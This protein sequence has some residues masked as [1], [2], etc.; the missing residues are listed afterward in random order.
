MQ[1]IQQQERQHVEIQLRNLFENDFD[2]ENGT[3]FN[4]SNLTI[5]KV[6]EERDKMLH[7]ATGQIESQK[8]QFEQFRQQQLEEIE[9]LK[10]A[11]EEERRVLEQEAYEKGFQ[12]GYEEGIQKANADM[13]QT[14]TIA[15]QVIEDA[16]INADKYLQDQEKVILD[17]ALKATE[18]IIGTALDLD[19][20][21]Y[22]SI[23]KKGLKEVR[24]MKE[25]KIYVS[26]TYHH[27]VSKSRDELNEIFPP[28]TPFFI[29]VN[30]ELNDTE[31]Y[32]E[33]N[34]GRIVLS[35]DD[36]LHELRLKL[37]EILDVRND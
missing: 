35:I 1:A 23:V 17:L 8:L 3:L 27:I 18:R 9:K 25:V 16:R 14:L 19:Q 26:P 30:E 7:E 21:L 36:Q 29:F 2:S 37:S 24:E 15:N 6:Y 4:R 10:Q 34:H 12:E 33:T 11:W 28:D 13:S 20:E 5:E 31:S 22:L 32:I